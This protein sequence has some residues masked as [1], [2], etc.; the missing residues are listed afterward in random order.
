MK[1][2]K[3]TQR[4]ANSKKIIA[5]ICIIATIIVVGLIYLIGF[6]GSILGW[7][8]LE[9]T[10]QEEQQQTSD[11]ED[12][13]TNPGTKDDTDE[14]TDQ[15]TD[16]IPV[17]QTLVATFTKLSQADGFITF[18]GEVNTNSADGSC[19]ITFTNTSDRPVTR[20]AAPTQVDSKSVCGPIQIPESEF[21]FLGEWTATFRFYT[22]DTQIVAERKITV[23]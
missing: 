16:E 14:G 6:K 21:S 5:T 10:S 11:P 19:S 3:Q 20:T 18:T 22:G 23:Q 9:S 8:P 13:T 4:S 7:Q 12:T 15:T 1:I 17:N 2:T